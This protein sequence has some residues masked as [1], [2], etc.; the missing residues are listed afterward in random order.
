M[1]RVL[2]VLLV[3]FV[4]LILLVLM[5]LMVLLVL[6][7]LLTGGA[8]YVTVEFR[9]ASC[10]FYWCLGFVLLARALACLI[11]SYTTQITKLTKLL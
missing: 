7:V 2:L 11:N 1:Y 8:N 4:L 3:L 5:L 10:L 9:S 6:L